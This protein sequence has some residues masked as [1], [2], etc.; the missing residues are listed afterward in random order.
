ME[1]LIEYDIESY[2]N[3]FTLTAYNPERDIYMQWEASWRK[4]NI[5]SMLEWIEYWAYHGFVMVGYNNLGY[6]YPVLHE[7]IT[8]PHCRSAAT[9][10]EHSAS[11]I[12]T[13]WNERFTNRIRP[14][15]MVVKQRDLM[16]I[17]HFDR[18]GNNVSLKELEFKMRMSS[19]DDLPFEPGYAIPETD[20]AA[21]TVLSYN[22]HDVHATR[23][24][25]QH[26]K[27]AMVLRDKLNAAYSGDY[28]NKS[29]SSIGKSVIVSE[30]K[31]H[32]FNC[33]ENGEPKQTWR[34]DIPLNSVIFPYINFETPQFN[35]V[36]NTV[37]DTVV[38]GTKGDFSLKFTIQDVEYSLALGGIHASVKNKTYVSTDTHIIEDADVT[39]FY[40]MIGIKNQISPAH[41][42][43]DVFGDT[44]QGL[45]DTRQTYDKKTNPSEN[46]AYKIIIN[47]IYGLT[48]DIHS[49]LL[50]PLYTMTITVNGQLM[51]L[52]LAERLI[53]Y[54]PDL[55][56]IQANTDGITVIYPR[57]HRYKYQAVCDWWQQLTTLNLEFAEYRLMAIRD[58][59]AY[60][61]VDMDGNRKCKGPY[62]SHDLQWI[63]DHSALVIAKAAEAAIVEGIPVREFITSHNDVYDFMLFNRVNRTAN[64][65]LYG[66]VQWDDTT[67]WDSVKLKDLTRS[68][69]YYISNS[70]AKLVKTMPPLKRRGEKVVMYMPGWKGKKETGLNKNCEVSTQ[71]EY[72]QAR[73]LGYRPKKGG[74]WLYGPV[75]EIGINKEWLVTVTNTI[76]DDM[77]FDINYNYYINEAEKLVNAT[78][79]IM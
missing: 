41:I 48:N 33:Y 18:Q 58:V 2:P 6:D 11:I 43:V 30:L 47:A 7:I 74:D 70:G 22:K 24:F 79:G 25:C 37:R 44:V 1:N 73:A 64:L 31:K 10:Y 14:N 16:C 21:D 27:N 56:V 36:L 19:I 9:I 71:H 3:I 69:R 15:A 72:N 34:S 39:S 60:I 13:P 61:S 54:V 5:P 76:T 45:F 65:H 62:N 51:L 17:H 53:K 12:A 40:P 28:S 4:N 35:A 46:Y 68:T 78:R 63:K 52:M 66:P 26:S 20:E 55:E 32:G 38:S 67:L 57:Q 23:L 59:N 77:K 8:N 50:D 75:R 42:P 29:E 49:P